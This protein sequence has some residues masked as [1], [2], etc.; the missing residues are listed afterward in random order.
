MLKEDLNNADLMA[1]NSRLKTVIRKM[2]QEKNK[3]SRHTPD[4]VI[5]GVKYLKDDFSKEY[6]DYRDFFQIEK[7]I[8]LTFKTSLG[9]DTTVLE[10][11][12]FLSWFFNYNKIQDFFKDSNL[13]FKDFYLINNN[14]YIKVTCLASVLNREFPTL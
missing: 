3:K 4:V 10:Q 7:K 2:K 13:K 12:E 14:Y 5:S 1:E 8:E 9:A 11:K 6:N